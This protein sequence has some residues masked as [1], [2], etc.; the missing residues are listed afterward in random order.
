MVEEIKLDGE[1]V[2]V[3]KIVCSDC[4]NDCF[5]VFSVTVA[6]K[7]IMKCLKCDSFKQKTDIFVGRKT[8]MGEKE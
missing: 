5:K 1:K 3:Q 2:K 7:I 6:D 8:I 4:G